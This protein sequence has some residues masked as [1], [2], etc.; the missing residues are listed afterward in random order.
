MKKAF[1]KNGPLMPI[2]ALCMPA[3]GIL[4]LV[5]TVGFIELAAGSKEWVKKMPLFTAAALCAAVALIPGSLAEDWL[6]AILFLLFIPVAFLLM[7]PAGRKEKLG[8]LLYA[9][10]CAVLVGLSI[11][12]VVLASGDLAQ[13]TLEQLNTYTGLGAAIFRVDLARC[14][15]GLILLLSKENV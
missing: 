3:S 14:A 15:T 9:L 4:S 2:L 13:V 8:F 5:S 11:G 6:M 1:P 12:R 10:L 7:K